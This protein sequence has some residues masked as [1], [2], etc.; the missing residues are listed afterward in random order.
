MP[1]TV[2][3]LCAEENYIRV[4]IQVKFW[5]SPYCKTCILS[6]MLE[7][8]VLYLPLGPWRVRRSVPTVTESHHGDCTGRKMICHLLSCPSTEAVLQTPAMLVWPMRLLWGCEPSYPQSPPSVIVSASFPEERKRKK[9]NSECQQLRPE[10]PNRISQDKEKALIQI[11][12]FIPDQFQR[13]APD[14]QSSELPNNNNQMKKRIF[15]SMEST[16]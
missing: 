1:H 14:I 12:N 6:Q 7:L 11:W 13:R 9:G 8:A 4:V 2:F 3:T 16:I 10:N 5:M 15:F